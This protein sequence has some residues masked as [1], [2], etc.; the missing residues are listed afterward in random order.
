MRTSDAARTGEVHFWFK[1]R[2]ILAGVVHGALVG[3]VLGCVILVLAMFQVPDHSRVGKPENALDWTTP[4]VMG[5][6]F[7]VGIGGIWGGIIGLV[8]RWK[9]PSRH[10]GLIAASILGTASGVL[11]ATSMLWRRA[12]ME[13]FWD[14]PAAV[15]ASRY[16]WLRGVPSGAVLGLILGLTHGYILNA[17]LRSSAGF[18]RRALLAALA[19]ITAGLTVGWVVSLLW[20]KWFHPW[21]NNSTGVG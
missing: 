13:T 12:P 16:Y 10:A 20:W 18:W 17:N 14:A 5:M 6:F 11:L 2:E 7:G 15:N 3:M 4:V 21:Y 19:A 1:P 9:A 8:S